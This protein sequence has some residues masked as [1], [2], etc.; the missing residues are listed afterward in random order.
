MKDSLVIQNLGI[1]WLIPTDNTPPLHKKK[2]KKK[3]KKKRLN[4]L[5]SIKWNTERAKLFRITHSYAKRALK[6][7]L[8]VTFYPNRSF[9][10]IW[11][12]N[13]W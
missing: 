6:I 12:V 11:Y 10:E 13:I 9:N 3:K 8:S 7:N 1:N 2:K 5:A 4:V